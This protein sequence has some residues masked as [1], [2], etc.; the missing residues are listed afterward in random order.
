[1]T[2]IKPEGRIDALTSLRFFA[3]LWV[4]FFHQWLT[5]YPKTLGSWFYQTLISKGFLGV[6]I[7]FL[8]S[9]YIL[10]YV[11]LKG[12][13]PPKVNKIFFWRARFA[14][15]YPVYALSFLLEAPFIM[16]SS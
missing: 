9:G 1:M 15:I 16:A 2:G 6:D 14:R 4:V 12:A 7:F 3:A 11:Y 13:R 8:L 10:A 5:Y